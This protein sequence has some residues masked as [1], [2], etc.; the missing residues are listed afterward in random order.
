MARS[1]EKRC[2]CPFC[3]VSLS[4]SPFLS[5]TFVSISCFKPFSPNP[6]IG[7]G[8]AVN[9]HAGLGRARSTKVSEKFWVENHAPHESAIAEVFR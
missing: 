6:A 5:L 7:L 8:S 4:P 1:G 3:L 2:R 9:F